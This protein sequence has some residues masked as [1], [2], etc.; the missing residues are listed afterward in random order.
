VVWAGKPARPEISPETGVTIGLYDD[1]RFWI[2]SSPGASYSS[3]NWWA[4]GALYPTTSQYGNECWFS[5]SKKGSAT[6]YV[7]TSN[8]CGVSP[9]RSRAVMVLESGG[10]TSY[11]FSP[12]PVTNQITVE[13]IDKETASKR[14]I[15]E[16]VA[17]FEKTN[18][19]ANSSEEYTIEIWHEKKG[20]ILSIN[21]IK[22]SET[23]DLSNLS[24]G[25]YYLHIITSTSVYKEMFIKE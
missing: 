18:L 21:S 24:R 12:N 17:T 7:T 19:S 11:A 6:V 9:T 5:A 8:I 4:S 20:K 2:T 16:P 25:T 14:S 10:G 1:I 22:Y 3:G 23:L 13:K 15:L